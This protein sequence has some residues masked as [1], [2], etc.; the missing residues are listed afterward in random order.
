[1][2]LGWFGDRINALMEIFHIYMTN[3]HFRQEHICGE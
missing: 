1:M 3:A 2:I